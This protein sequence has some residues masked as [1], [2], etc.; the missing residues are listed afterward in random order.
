MMDLFYFLQVHFTSQ[1]N[2]QTGVM[3]ITCGLLWC[4]YR[5]FGLTLTA[6]IHR[7]ESTGEQ[8]M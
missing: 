6:P 4:F 7:R 8:V 3:L 5:L 1:D 2:W